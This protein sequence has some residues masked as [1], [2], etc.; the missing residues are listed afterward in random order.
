MEYNIM[1]KELIEINQ[2]KN[3][4]YISFYDYTIPLIKEG[5]GRSIIAPALM[6]KANGKFLNYSVADKYFRH[7]VQKVISVYHQENNSPKGDEAVPTISSGVTIDDRSKIVLENASF[8]DR[9]VITSFYHEIDSYDNSLLFQTD[10]IK[11]IMDIIRYAITEFSKFANVNIKLSN[12]YRGYRDNYVIACEKDGLYTN[13]MIFYNKTSDNTYQIS[14]GNIGEVCQP[15]VVDISFLNDKIRI[16]G[17]YKDLIITNEFEMDQ[18]GGKYLYRVTNSKDLI[19]YDVGNLEKIEEPYS[20]LVN[21]DYGKELELSWYKL[22]WLAFVGSRI[23]TSI[24]DDVTS[25]TTNHIMYLDIINDNF[26]KREFYTKKLSRDRINKQKPIRLIVDSLRKI[27][28]GFKKGDNYLIETNFNNGFGDG[29]YQTDYNNRYFYH[30]CEPMDLS[31]I[32]KDSLK[33]ISKD[34]IMTRDDLNMDSKVK[35]I[36]ER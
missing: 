2:I 30:L 5:N 33:P 18:N 23:T 16:E 26:Y 6:I 14:I 31:S 17:R 9:N 1:D 35:R 19:A 10:E 29:D 11:S 25:I 20:N 32:T 27:T 3:I 36:G 34:I 12:N 15:Y 21:L 24:I 7:F 28:F 8:L 4:E 22:P 13:L